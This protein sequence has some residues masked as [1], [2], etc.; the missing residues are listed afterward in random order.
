MDVTLYVIVWVVCGVLAYGLMQG[1]FARQFPM[2][3]A[4][5]RSNDQISYLFT[6][7]LG[8]IGLLVGGLFCLMT[9]NSP[10]FRWTPV[11]DEEA[12]AEYESRYPY[13]D[14][15]FYLKTGQV[16]VKEE[17]EHIAVE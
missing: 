2:F 7:M 6:G 11:S 8:P 15:D 3:A 10:T 17:F 14:Y 12:R 16:K 9:W 5:R 4:Y 1:M 13:L